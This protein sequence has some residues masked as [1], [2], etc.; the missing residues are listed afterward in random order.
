MRS[1]IYELLAY[2]QACM[3]HRV[4]LF[5]T[6][7]TVVRQALLSVGFS[8]QEYWNVLPFPLPGDIPDPGIKST[9]LTLAGRFFTIE[10]PGKPSLAHRTCSI[11]VMNLIRIMTSSPN[12]LKSSW[13]ISDESD[14]NNDFTQFTEKQLV[15]LIIKVTNQLVFVLQSV[16]WRV[17]LMS[18]NSVLLFHFLRSLL[19]LSLLPSPE[20][21]FP[22]FFYMVYS[23]FLFY[24]SMLFYS[25]I[26]QHS[27]S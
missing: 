26:R 13:F 22:Q 4:L 17:F 16:I 25:H 21:L 24:F 9:S 12:S 6:F 15:H 8:R 10:P 18:P 19:H 27:G 7:W 11:E 2:M 3:L 1:Y 5:T 23:Y 20:I 14:Q